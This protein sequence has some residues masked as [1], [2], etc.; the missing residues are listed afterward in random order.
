[1]LRLTMR[2]R[3]YSWRFLTALGP[4]YGDTGSATCR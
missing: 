3:G 4:E 1:V 2:P